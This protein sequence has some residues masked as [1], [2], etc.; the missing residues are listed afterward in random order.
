MIV[1]ALHLRALASRV[2]ARTSR[3]GSASTPRCPSCS[4]ST[5]RAS[6]AP[7]AHFANLGRRRIALGHLSIVGS[8]RCAGRNHGRDV[9]R[10]LG[11]LFRGGALPGGKRRRARPRRSWRLTAGH[12]ELA[13]TRRR[14][15]STATPGSSQCLPCGRNGIR[16]CR[17]IRRRRRRRKS[18][19][20]TADPRFYRRRSSRHASRVGSDQEPARGGHRGRFAPGPRPCA[21]S[22]RRCRR[23]SW[24]APRPC[25]PPRMRRRRQRRPA[26]GDRRR[27]P[28]ELSALAPASSSPP[29]ARW[30][31]ILEAR[32]RRSRRIGSSRSPPSRNVR[33]GRR[34]RRPRRKLQARNRA[35]S[36][37]SRR[38][39]QARN[40]TPF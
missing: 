16:C 8:R 19:R 18:D 11:L 7:S 31:E 17:G 13:V 22:F 1:R 12:L 24:E 26:G 23:R 3:I 15:D 40:R 39:L 10:R 37:P 35:F 36:T 9:R 33:A 30:A 5:A 28:R 38:K 6:R 29:P 20:R 32:R 25:S 21:T 2:A 4:G 27:C 14:A 34:R